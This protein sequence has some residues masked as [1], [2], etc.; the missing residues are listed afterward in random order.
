MGFTTP[1]NT[2]GDYQS[3]NPLTLADQ[4]YQKAGKTAVTWNF[5][6][7]PSEAWKNTLGQAMLAYAQ[8]TGKWDAVTSAFVDNWAKEYKL[9]NG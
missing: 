4:V 8:G 6:T 9:A 3:T 5:T 1:F 2:F 7:M